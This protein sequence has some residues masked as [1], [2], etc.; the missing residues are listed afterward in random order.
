MRKIIPAEPIKYVLRANP[1]AHRVTHNNREFPSLILHF[2]VPVVPNMKITWEISVA[3]LQ[4]YVVFTYIMI[5][6]SNQFTAKHVWR[7]L[8]AATIFV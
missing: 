1:T 8:F 3:K 5:L 2:A 7:T 6:L 4:T